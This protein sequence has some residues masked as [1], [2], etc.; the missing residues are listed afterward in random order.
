MAKTVKDSGVFGEDGK[1]P[2]ECWLWIGKPN[3]KGYGEFGFGSARRSY[4]V[5]RFSYEYH[6]YEIPA[7]QQ[8]DHL[9]RNRLCVNPSHLEAV[10]SR[11]N[12]MRGKN[13]AAEYARR[14]HCNSGHAF[15]LENTY[16]RDNGARRCKTCQREY[17]RNYGTANR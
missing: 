1:Y 4:S 6:L 3:K 16:V 17:M 5:H 10:T 11:E 13:H 14:T 7:G 9:C 8:I 2:T 15:T 12:T